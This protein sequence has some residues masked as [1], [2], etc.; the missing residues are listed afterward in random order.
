MIYKYSTI[1]H[2][3]KIDRN[4]INLSGRYRQQFLHRQFLLREKDGCMIELWIKRAWLLLL[5]K[6]KNKIEKVLRTNLDLIWTNI[7]PT[8]KQDKLKYNKNVH[9]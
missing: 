1:I 7:K 3:D 4:R 5:L 2:S 8:I 6:S 9:S